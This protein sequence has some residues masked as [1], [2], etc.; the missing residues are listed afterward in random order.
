MGEKYRNIFVGFNYDLNPRTDLYFN[1]MMSDLNYGMQT[2]AKH[3]YMGQSA[4]EFKSRLG[5]Y[6]QPLSVFMKTRSKA[7]NW[8]AR[9][10]SGLLFPPHKGAPVRDLFKDESQPAK[11]PATA[12]VCDH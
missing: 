6:Q 5:C 4:N 7:L 2:G 12:T 11:S 1:M 10:A 3:V 9:I 8:L